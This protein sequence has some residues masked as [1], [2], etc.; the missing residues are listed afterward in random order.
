MIVILSMHRSGSSL[1]AGLLRENGIHLGDE[2]DLIE[3]NKDNIKGFMERYDVVRLNEKILSSGCH[4]HMLPALDN[5]INQGVYKEQ[6]NEVAKKIKGQ[7]IQLIKDPRL[8]LTL[9][10][11]TPFFD[12]V[13]LIFLSRNPVDVAQSL[14]RRQSY[15]LQAGLALWEFYNYQALKH[16]QGRNVFHINFDQLAK[17]PVETINRTLDWL[18]QTENMS[19]SNYGNDNAKVGFYDSK[20]HTDL[21]K[22]NTLD[23]LSPEQQ[24]LYDY[25][26]SP[27]KSYT[28]PYTS[29]TMRNSLLLMSQFAQKGY[30]PGSGRMLDKKSAKHLEKLKIKVKAHNE[31][32]RKV[33]ELSDLISLFMGSRGAIVLNYFYL[34]KNRIFRIAKK[35]PLDSINHVNEQIKRKL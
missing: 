6:I 33:D 14:F 13:S 23:L 34:I 8:C 5:D 17:H 16:S 18:N 21:K 12:D 27:K 2:K 3:G 32:R 35:S 24:A 15:P 26:Q 9:D 1:L 4:G 29:F 11:W 19:D 20:L 7:N 30:V 28:G 25:L 31:F 10:K 22:D